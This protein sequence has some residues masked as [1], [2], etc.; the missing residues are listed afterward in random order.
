MLEGR[1]AKR[2][3]GG[4][5]HRLRSTL[6]APLMICLTCGQVKTITMAS[7]IA[8]AMNFVSAPRT[9]VYTYQ[10]RPFVRTAEAIFLLH[11][12]H[13]VPLWKGMAEASAVNWTV[14]VSSALSVCMVLWNPNFL[15]LSMPV[16]SQCKSPIE[17]K[18]LILT[19]IPPF[20]SMAASKT[21]FIGRLI[22]HSPNEQYICWWIRELILIYVK[23]SCQGTLIASWLCRIKQAREQLHVRFRTHLLRCL[24]LLIHPEA[25]QLLIPEKWPT[26][27]MLENK[28]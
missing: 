22:F 6:F 8:G 11:M 24:S 12:Q 7:P 2:R 20:S 19:V 21:F 18:V 14:R 28:G 13:E 23:T 25:L 3:L 16:I 4:S 27:I 15:E 5:N 9:C 17:S 10:R 1:G 26:E